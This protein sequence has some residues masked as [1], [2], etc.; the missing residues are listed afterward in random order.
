MNKIK[1]NKVKNPPLLDDI[2]RDIMNS[3]VFMNNSIKWRQEKDGK[4]ITFN[5]ITG[6]ICVMNPTLAQIYLMTSD[7]SGTNFKSILNS[8][9]EKYPEVTEKQ[10]NQDVL[11]ALTWL[12]VNGFIYLEKYNKRISIVD[13]IEKICSDAL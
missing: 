2:K 5:P 11:F 10:L 3:R 8:L 6:K 13:I 1:N 9:R 12:F 7:K 4:I